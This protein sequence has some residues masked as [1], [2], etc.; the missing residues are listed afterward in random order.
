MWLLLLDGLFLSVAHWERHCSLKSCGLVV[1]CLSYRWPP[2]LNISSEH[3]TTERDST[4]YFSAFSGRHDCFWCP[5][6]TF[7]SQN[8][9]KAPKIKFGFSGVLISFL[10]S[11]ILLTYPTIHQQLLLRIKPSYMPRIIL[12]DITHSFVLSQMVLSIVI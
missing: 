4:I 11:L 1:H 12:I 5:W 8:S 3:A 7:Q 9:R 10:P 2:L 6:K